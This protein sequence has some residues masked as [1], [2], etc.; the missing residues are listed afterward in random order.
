MVR[1]PFLWLLWF[2]YRIYYIALVTYIK[3]VFSLQPVLY[4]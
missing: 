4:Y 2:D 3:I 1:G